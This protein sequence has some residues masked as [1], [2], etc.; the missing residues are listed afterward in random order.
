MVK[1]T[2]DILRKIIRETITE[3]T[4]MQTL[5]HF[6][7]MM[8]LYGMVRTGVVNLSEYQKEESNG[9]NFMSF[10]RHKSFREGYAAA[11]GMCLPVRIEFDMAKVNSLHGAKTEPFEFYSPSRTKPT[12]G[13]WYD[14]HGYNPRDNDTESAKEMYRR[15]YKAYH[16][17]PY[18]GY[19]EPE[20][21]YMNQAEERLVSNN[22]SITADAILRIDIAYFDAYHEYS[23]YPEEYDDEPL[24]EIYDSDYHSEGYADMMEI[25]EYSEK[26]IRLK[27]PKIP[28]NKIFVYSNEADFI[29]QTNKCLTLPEFVKLKRTRNRKNVAESRLAEMVSETIT[30]V[31]NEEGIHIKDEN[32]GKF[33]ATKERTGKSTEEL[34][35]SKNPVTRKRA[36]FA[37]NAKKWKK[38]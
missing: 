20:H 26:I 32:K 5:Y 31:L 25:D 24:N 17:D 3:S 13:E 14:E 35:H 37:Q 4:N 34:T 22:N 36:I 9:K 19:D 2:E 15:E 11:E 29:R 10:T 30:R 23:H 16:D 28:F 8:A 12:N 7:D 33:N 1:I 21:E 6:T 38:N 27:N 18:A